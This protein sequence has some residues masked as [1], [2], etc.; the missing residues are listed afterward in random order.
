MKRI[1]YW[2]DS[3][4]VGTGYGTVAKYILAALV[5]VGFSVDAVALSSL[6]AVPPE[7]YPIRVQSVSVDGGDPYGTR[8]LQETLRTNRYDAV[9]VINDAA[10]LQLLHQVLAKLEHRPRVI[11]YLPIDWP[12]PEH[13]M[14][15]A[16]ACDRIVACANFAQ[17][18][19]Q[20]GTRHDVVDLIPHGVDLGVFKP[21]RSDFRAELEA[22][23]L[24]PDRL[25]LTSIAVNSPKKNLPA[26]LQATAMVDRPRVALYVHAAPVDSGGNLRDAAA[27]LGL[28]EN[29]DVFF[30]AA[31][32]PPHGP[33][34]TQADVARILAGSDALV[35]STRSEGWCLPVTEAFAVGCPVIA[36]AHTAIEEQAR[37]RAILVPAE[38][39]DWVGELGGYRPRIPPGEI[40]QG[41][42]TFA[43][44]R[45]RRSQR[46]RVRRARAFA[47]EHDWRRVTPSWVRLFREELRCRTR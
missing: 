30:P 26:L 44:E 2:G 21:Q 32:P 33:C 4:L 34:S 19:L 20:E 24:E 17:R 45:G 12:L 22:R 8:A 28:V 11:A 13:A 40:A 7:H 10:P 25:L 16:A 41:I 27:E 47:R 38:E 3:P 42:R 37:G 23:G 29:R 15:A 14:R 5:G 36:P 6:G 46:E 9:L 18:L 31:A 39:L 35:L 1:L 43:R